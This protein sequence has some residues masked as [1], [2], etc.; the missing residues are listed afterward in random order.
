M[1]HMPNETAVPMRRWGAFPLGD[2]V[3]GA[4]THWNGV[5]WRTIPSELRL[6]S[7]LTER[8]GR[9]AIPADLT[10]QDFGV[11]YDELEP[12]FDRFEKL[13]GTSGKAGNLRGQMQ[14][15]RQSVRRRAPERISEQADDHVAGR[16]HLHRGR[17]EGSAMH[18][19][20]D[21]VIE[22]QRAPTPIPKA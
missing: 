14:R 11:T 8:Y 13:C 19:V 1:R 18:P 2:G 4:G 22:Q 20:P 15:R 10:I 16:A 6:R 7:H 21:A 3:G 12:H 5:T 17:E 9:N